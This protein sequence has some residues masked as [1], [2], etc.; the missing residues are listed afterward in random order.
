MHELQDL[1]IMWDFLVLLWEMKHEVK[2]VT[3]VS[4]F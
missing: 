4:Q 3:G 1:E 2:L